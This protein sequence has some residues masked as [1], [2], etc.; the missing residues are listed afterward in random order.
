MRR[1]ALTLLCLLLS[2][3]A[4]P[5]K[6]LNIY[7]VDVEGGQSTLIV[8]PDGQSLLVDA[9]WP[10]F[11]DRDPERIMAAAR[12][13]GVT[14]IDYLLVT[15]FHGDHVGGV[16]ALARRIP[17]KTFVDYGAPVESGPEMLELVKAYD[18]VRQQGRQIHPKPGDRLPLT[19][20]EVDIVSAGGATLAKPLSAA[21]QPNPECA[22]FDRH[23]DDPSENARAIGFR[24]RFGNFRFVDL[25]DLTWNM[26]RQLVCPNNL[27]G[28]VDAYLVA[29]HG[30]ADSSPP[31]LLSALR[32]IVAI[33]DN[34]TTKGGAP[35][36]FARLHQLPDLQD[37]WQLN[38]ST[39]QG[40]QNFGD[41]FIAN[42]EA[43]KTGFWLKLAASN[44]GTFSVTNARTGVSKS[45]RPAP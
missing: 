14:Q 34:G 5:T 38:R 13:A 25:G 31:G 42:L 16:P 1:F 35:E 36:T 6:T 43:G 27:L 33:L 29:H 21:G 10:G 2:A 20:V 32:P 24:L 23:A 40:A 30:N 39:N 45:Y 15:H 28:R 44:D 9:G 11:N 4:A 18:L 12:D 17:I 8:T 19:G 26:E 3:A 37:V 22:A 7:F 41:P